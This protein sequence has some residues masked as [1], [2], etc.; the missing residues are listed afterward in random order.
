MSKLDEGRLAAAMVSRALR[1]PDIG[2]RAQF[3]RELVAHAVAG[4]ALTEGE[5]KAA[6]WVYRVADSLVDRPLPT[7]P[8]K[9][10]P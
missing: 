1:R 10:Q 5:R 4:L 6:E 3:L 9:D 7:E 2:D 8:R